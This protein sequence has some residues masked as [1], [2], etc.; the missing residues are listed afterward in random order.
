MTCDRSPHKVAFSPR[1]RQK[2][3]GQAEKRLSERKLSEMPGSQSRGK[4]A[5]S[6]ANRYTGTPSRFAIRFATSTPEYRPPSM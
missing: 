5:T 1:L 4:R 3:N 6:A 2:R